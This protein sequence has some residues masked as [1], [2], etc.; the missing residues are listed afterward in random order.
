MRSPGKI[1]HISSVNFDFLTIFLVQLAGPIEVVSSTGDEN[2]QA[3]D[4]RSSEHC[5]SMASASETINVEYP[6]QENCDYIGSEQ[7]Q[8]HHAPAHICDIGSE[9]VMQITD[10]SISY[11][12][13]Q[14]DVGTP[15]EIQV[16]HP[17]QM[18][19]QVR[20]F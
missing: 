9:N 5:N 19:Q 15:D 20:T 13:V 2:N 3:I 1:F 16:M 17:N 6:I 10:K 12:S 7:Q 4:N 14:S 18:N 8:V 11:Q